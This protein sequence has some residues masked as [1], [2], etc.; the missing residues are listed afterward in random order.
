MAAGDLAWR[1]RGWPRARG[2]LAWN[3][4]AETSWCSR[5]SSF[6]VSVWA[7]NLAAAAAASLTSSS[8]TK[9]IENKSEKSSIVALLSAGNLAAVSL[10][11]WPEESCGCV[12]V[13]SDTTRWS[14]KV[15]SFHVLYA[16]GGGSLAVDEDGESWIV[17]ALPTVVCGMS[18]S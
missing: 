2:P 1:S 18:A 13:A 3:I 9:C 7:G 5:L 6:A 17:L 4:I 8:V 11:R 15:I 10:A 16:A 14:E 12:T